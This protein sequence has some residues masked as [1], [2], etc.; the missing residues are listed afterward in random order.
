MPQARWTEYSSRA[1]LL[2]VTLAEPHADRTLT[3]QATIV[4]NAILALPLWQRH[5]TKGGHIMFARVTTTQASPENYDEGVR[6]IQEQLIPAIKA[7]PGAQGGYWLADRQTGKTIAITL[8]E[9]EAAMLA[10]EQAGNQVR[11]QASQATN[12]AVQSVERFEVV[13]HL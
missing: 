6:Y 1:L 9:S 12:S 4:V 7:I 8:W 2:L 11:A 10:S 5:V 3:A 13:A